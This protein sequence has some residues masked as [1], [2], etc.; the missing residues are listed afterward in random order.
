MKFDSPNGEYSVVVT[1][2][3]IYNFIPTAPGDGSSAPCNVEIIDKEGSSMGRITVSPGYM[4]DD[5]VWTESGAE[6]KLVGEWNF[7]NE[8]AYY[9]SEDQGHKVWVK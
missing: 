2:K 6:I 5:L 1:R 3:F 4:V 7:K 8:T 9:W